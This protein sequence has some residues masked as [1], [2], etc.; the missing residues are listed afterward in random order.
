MKG[1]EHDLHRQEEQ[2]HNKKH[3][4]DKP[5]WKRIHHTWSFWIFLVLML[6]AITYY[7]LSDNL[8]LRPRIQP[9]QAP[10]ENSRIP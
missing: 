2:D 8:S 4:D 3:H 6:A 5:Y 9:Q 1:N 7:A 10:S